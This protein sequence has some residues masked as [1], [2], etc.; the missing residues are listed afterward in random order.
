[1]ISALLGKQTTTFA[2]GLAPFHPYFLESCQQTQFSPQLEAQHSCMHQVSAKHQ[3]KSCF[4]VKRLNEK[5][6][7]EICSIT[8]KNRHEDVLEHHILSIINAGLNNFV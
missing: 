3:I 5:S 8:N 7:A 1:M 6:S 2:F 4:S